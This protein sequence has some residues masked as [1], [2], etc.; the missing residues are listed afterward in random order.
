MKFHET[1]D[2]TVAVIGSS[3]PPTR[4]YSAE[5]V[6]DAEDTFEK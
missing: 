3:M 5:I 1:R 2:F 6:S 4:L